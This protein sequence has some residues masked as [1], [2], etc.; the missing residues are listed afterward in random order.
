MGN[1]QPRC[2]TPRTRE[3]LREYLL[4][5]NIVSEVCDGVLR[6]ADQLG[7]GLSTVEFLSVNVREDSGN[8]TI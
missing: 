5:A 8:L 4:L 1:N 2:Y 3:V 7:L 6:V